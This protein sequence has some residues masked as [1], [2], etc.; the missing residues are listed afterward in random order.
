[1]LR[2]CFYTDT[3]FL[4]DFQWTKMKQA[5]RIRDFVLETIVGPARD[6]GLRDV[7][8]RA[9]DIHRLMGLK[10]AMPAV[11]S[12]LGSN[13]FLDLATV[14]TVN[15]T[16]PS[17]GSNAIFTFGLLEGR[18]NHRPI[19][20]AES[21]VET[22]ASTTRDN[23][24]PIELSDALVLVS[25]VKSKLAY[26]APACDLYT[27]PMFQMARHLAEQGAD[28]R[29]LSAKY[30]LVDPSSVIEPYDLTLNRMGVQDRRKWADQVMQHLLPLAE[31]FRKVVFFAGELYRDFLIPPLRGHGIEVEV[32]MRGLR[33]GEQLAWLAG[34]Q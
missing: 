27:S 25:C 26:A 20:R 29:V 8:V 3:G 12:A 32:P 34:N 7:V 17:N 10:N 13:K 19:Y 28:W 6:Q 5:D 1:M 21:A 9:G 22:K 4:S 33:Q 24:E 23:W 15:R 16:G 11:C 31:Q 18:P 30:G 14:E 2:I